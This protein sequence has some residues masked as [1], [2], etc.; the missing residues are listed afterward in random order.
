MTGLTNSYRTTTNVVNYLASHDR[1]R[2]MAEEGFRTLDKEAAVVRAKLGAALL[3]TAMGVP[4]L[5]MG[6]KFGEYTRQTPKQSNKLNWPLF[7][8]GDFAPRVRRA[9][10][11]LKFL[12]SSPNTS[13]CNRDSRL[14]RRDILKFATGSPTYF[15]WVDWWFPIPLSIIEVYRPCSHLNYPKRMGNRLTVVSP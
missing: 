7:K 3:M 14:L 9:G 10:I 1:D 15:S 11:C 13:I 4:M 12:N 5:S 6:E 8:D 2:L